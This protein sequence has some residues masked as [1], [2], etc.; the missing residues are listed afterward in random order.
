VKFGSEAERV[1][2]HTLFLLYSSDD[3]Y[4][5]DFNDITINKIAGKCGYE[6]NNSQFIIDVI[7]ALVDEA[8][9][10]KD[11]YWEYTIITSKETQRRWKLAA[12]RRNIN[13]DALPYW[14]QGE[15]TLENAELI[16]VIMTNFKHHIHAQLPSDMIERIDKNIKSLKRY[17]AE[18]GSIENIFLVAIRRMLDCN[19]NSPS[20][21]F[22]K[23]IFG[24]DTYLL[25]PTPK[26]EES[27]S[28]VDLVKS[29]KEADKPIKGPTLKGMK[30]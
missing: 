28:Y 1:L 30:S 5:L 12:M 25:R 16:D 10:N 3:G 17:K 8:F 18:Y 6:K 4:Y 26:E 14:I 2:I 19:F 23:G 20:R 21:F 7:E 29:K 24:S 15:R 9:F 27:G 11:Y 22:Y 13:F